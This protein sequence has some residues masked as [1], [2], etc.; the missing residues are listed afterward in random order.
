MQIVYTSTEFSTVDSV[1]FLIDGNKKD[2]LGSEGQW[3]GS[4]L[5]RASFN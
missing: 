3:I 4:P 2:Y 1:Q 5:S